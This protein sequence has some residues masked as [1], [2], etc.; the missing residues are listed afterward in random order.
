MFFSLKLLWKANILE[1]VKITKPIL[2]WITHS[3][4]KILVLLCLWITNN[5]E[6]Y[7]NNQFI[8]KA[9]VANYIYQL[10]RVAIVNRLRYSWLKRIAIVNSKQLP[11]TRKRIASVK[12][13]KDIKDNEETI[14][15]ILTNTNLSHTYRNIDKRKTKQIKKRR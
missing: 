13:S 15:L 1:L 12:H 14:P 10:K 8:S 6:S 2:L 5:I 3:N 7:G 9:I 11:P 4:F